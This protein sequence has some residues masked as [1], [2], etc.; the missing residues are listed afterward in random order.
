[1]AGCGTTSAFGVLHSITVAAI[2]EVVAFFT[3]THCL[4]R[5]QNGNVLITSDLTIAASQHHLKIPNPTLHLMVDEAVAPL[6]DAWCGW[7]P[8]CACNMA[9]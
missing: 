3:G 6:S 5:D 2:R 7:E 8:D 1:M 9:G 4:I